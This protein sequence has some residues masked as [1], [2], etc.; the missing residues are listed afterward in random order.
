MNNPSPGDEPE[1][2]PDPTLEVYKK[3]LDEMRNADVH[4][5]PEIKRLLREVKIAFV[6][7]HKSQVK[8]PKY[9]V[10]VDDNY[11]FMDEEERY[12]LGVFDTEEEA[13]QAAK[14]LIDEFLHQ[15][16]CPGTSAKN[17]FEAY[18]GF[19]DDPWI[20]L[21]AFHAWDYARERCAEICSGNVDGNDQEGEIMMSPSL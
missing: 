21:S 17:L 18:C 10:Y 13:V 7:Y 4:D 3:L 9:T 1:P 20:L 8:D 6:N 11:H 19:G 15:T 14:G 12:T 5:T 2:E 16:Y